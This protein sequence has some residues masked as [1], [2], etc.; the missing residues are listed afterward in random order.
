MVPV[1]VLTLKSIKKQKSQYGILKIDI[2]VLY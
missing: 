2:L 1:E